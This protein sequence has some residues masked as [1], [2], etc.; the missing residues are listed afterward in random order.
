MGRRD[1]PFDCD[2]PNGSIYKSCS[3]NVKLRGRGEFKCS[4]VVEEKLQFGGSYFN[5]F[6]NRV[7]FFCQLFFNILGNNLRSFNLDKSF[8]YKPQYFPLLSSFSELAIE[9]LIWVR[10]YIWT[11]FIKTM[12]LETGK[13]NSLVSL[14]LLTIYQQISLQSVFYDLSNLGSNGSHVTLFT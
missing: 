14:F 2:R 9:P 4:K 10:V 7:S 5:L 12:K 13:S 11:S 6:S 8:S 1:C 3:T